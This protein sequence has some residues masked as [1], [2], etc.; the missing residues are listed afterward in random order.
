MEQSKPQ[1]LTRLIN[2]GEKLAARLGEAGI[3]SEQD[4]R[5]VGAVEAHRRIKALYP[6]ETLPVCYYLYSFEGA[7]TGQHWNEIGKARK[8]ALQRQLGEGE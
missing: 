7:L 2:I 1:T 6:D 8:L 4:L 3:H 5:S